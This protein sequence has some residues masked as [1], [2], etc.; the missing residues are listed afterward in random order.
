[1]CTGCEVHYDKLWKIRRHVM[2]AH[3][4]VKYQCSHCKTLFQRPDRNHP[5]CRRYGRE[6]VRFDPIYSRLL[7]DGTFDKRYGDDA[8]ELLRQ[9]KN[10][11]CDRHIKLLSHRRRSSS[12]HVPQR[13]SRS[14]E[15]VKRKREIS[16]PTRKGHGTPPPKLKAKQALDLTLPPVLSPLPPSPKV[17]V[18]YED[19]SG[20]EDIRCVVPKSPR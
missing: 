14:E 11:E 17:T 13:Q 16:P 12:Q 18:V 8:L 20:D 1:M 15:R 6:V 9:F 5:C 7:T 19:I 2:E 3:F 10:N 4:F